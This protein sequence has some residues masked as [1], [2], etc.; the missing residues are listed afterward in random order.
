MV[1]KN[2]WYNEGHDT[3]VYTVQLPTNS[4]NRQWHVQTDTRPISDR[5]KGRKALAKKGTA[6]AVGH[7]EGRAWNE[8]LIEDSVDAE[9]SSTDED[10]PQHDLSRQTSAYDIVRQ[11]SA[12]V[13]EDGGV[14]E[15][16]DE[17]GA[18]R[19][20]DKE[21]GKLLEVS[22][23]EG[24]AS[25]GYSL[26]TSGGKFNYS[27]DFARRIQRNVRTGTVREIRRNVPEEETAGF[28]MP[29]RVETATGYPA[30]AHKRGETAA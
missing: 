16:M 20:M 8:R 30:L 29:Q 28:D 17:E 12:F 4:T 5:T 23:N 15:Y 10:S 25:V 11:S 6:A 1:W 3:L 27:V 24:H 9:G 26:Q 21:I 13:A 7:R 2:H 22:A 19:P 18:W 14:W